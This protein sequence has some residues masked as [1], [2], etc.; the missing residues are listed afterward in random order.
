MSKNL[1]IEIRKMGIDD[2]SPVFHMGE[3]LFTAERF[4]TLYRTWDEYEVTHFFNI[5]PD[6]CMIACRDDKVVGFALGNT[7]EKPQTAWNYGYLVWLGVLKRYQKHGVAKR[8]LDSMSDELK[9]KGIRILIVD[10]QAD[11]KGAIKFFTKNGFSHSS[12][13]VYMSLNMETAG[14]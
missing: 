13:H 12:K 3:R 10:T 2:I 9:K 14:E 8:L 6:L 5:E 7:I 1:K 11:N 4:P